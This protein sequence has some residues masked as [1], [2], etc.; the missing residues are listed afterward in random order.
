MLINL[1]NIRFRHNETVGN[2]YVNQT[3]F[4]NTSSINVTFLLAETS[5]AVK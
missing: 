5:I 2:D 3:S 4:I 1:I